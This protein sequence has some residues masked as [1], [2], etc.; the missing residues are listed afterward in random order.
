MPWCSLAHGLLRFTRGTYQNACQRQDVCQSLA[1]LHRKW[2]PE[3]KSPSRQQEH[4]PRAF[5]DRADRQ[6]GLLGQL[7]FHRVNNRTG[8]TS[9]QCISR[10]PKHVSNGTIPD[11]RARTYTLTQTV[12]RSFL[13]EL[14]FKG[15]SGSADGLGIRTI[16]P[17]PPST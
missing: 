13:F 16:S 1:I 9:E 17:F 3:K 10:I 15:S 5:I 2:L 8:N 7:G 4:I 14:Q 12:D 6:S 11:A